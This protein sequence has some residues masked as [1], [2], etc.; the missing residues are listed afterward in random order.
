VLYG[1]EREG[2]IT[3]A[4][5]ILASSLIWFRSRWFA[6]FAIFNLAMGVYEIARIFLAGSHYPIGEL[7]GY[8]IQE[9]SRP[10]IGLWLLVA[11]ALLTLFIAG[12]RIYCRKNSRRKENQSLFTTAI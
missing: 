3:L 1:F 2:L 4:A 6:F 5:G 10:G 11:S 9:K 7:M 8:S 12:N